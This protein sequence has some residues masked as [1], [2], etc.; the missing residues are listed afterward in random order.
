QKFSTNIK[1][2]EIN[3]EKLIFDECSLNKLKEI[4]F[5]L[6]EESD[7]KLFENDYELFQKEIFEAE[8]AKTLKTLPQVI[9]L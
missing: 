7:D 1:S 9:R 4:L 6:V 2:E 3:N 8:E 5:Q